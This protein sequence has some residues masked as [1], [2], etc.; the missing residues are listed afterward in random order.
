MSK[1]VY[2]CFDEYELIDISAMNEYDRHIEHSELRELTLEKRA[3]KKDMPLDVSVERIYISKL[4]HNAIASLPEVQQ[5][6]LL[7]YYF[8]KKSYK[9][10]AKEEGC[11]YQ[12]VQRSIYRA[13][14][15]LKIE[16]KQFK[17]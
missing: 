1:E 6:R 5:K 7:K 13:K 2:D 11:K 12:C 4:V 10:I 9:E 17:D 3:L 8:E 16:L 15:K 14:E